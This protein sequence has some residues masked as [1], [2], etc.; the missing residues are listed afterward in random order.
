MRRPRLL[1]TLPFLL[2]GL[3]TT[4]AVALILAASVAVQD[5]PVTQSQSFDDEEDWSVTRWDRAGAVL[6]HSVRTEPARGAAW[7]PQQAAGAPD[8]P[9]AGDHASA[10]ASLGQDNGPE[11]LILHYP[12]PVT[13][14]ELH[15][16]ENY[17]PGALVKVTVFDA[18]DHETVA[19]TGTDPTP[20]GTPSGVSKVPLNTDVKTRKVKIHLASEKVPGWNEI[21]AVA[22]IDD[23]GQTQWAKRVSAS[24]TYARPANTAGNAI[25]DP[26]TIL[27]SWT[28]LTAARPQ[29]GD[30]RK[31]VLIDARGWPLLALKSERDLGAR[32]PV[33]TQGSGPV[34]TGFVPQRGLVAVSTPSTSFGP[35]PLPLRPIWPG[36][37]GNTAFYA[38]LWAAL[39]YAVAVPRRFV[40]E[41]ARVRSGQCVRCG[42]DLGYDFQSGCPECGWRRDRATVATRLPIEQP[43]NG[44]AP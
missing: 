41:V 29:P 10:W 2:L 3:G 22:L 43:A 33:L 34:Y 23:A 18:D 1:R 16:Y 31:E 30:T 5:G 12:D 15:V 28:G 6:I 21:D 37:L 11:W 39:W 36:L 27:P 8:T 19:W 17:C 25:G 40:R 44:D 35:T 14:R 9:G 13:P 42:Y 26:A 7:S 38:L 24:S 4:I 32:A 20:A